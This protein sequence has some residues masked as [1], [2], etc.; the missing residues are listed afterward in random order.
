MLTTILI[1][2]LIL[3][4]VGALPTW[5]Y[6]RDWGYAPG[7]GLGLILLIVVVPGAHRPYLS[8][9]T[10]HFAPLLPGPHR[11]SGADPKA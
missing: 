6:S 2:V 4:L 3:A 5:G 8:R 10:L 9:R 1:I 11:D 7:G